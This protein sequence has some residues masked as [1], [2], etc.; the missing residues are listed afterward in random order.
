MIPRENFL[1]PGIEKRD[2]TSHC[3]HEAN[4]MC[5][6]VTIYTLPLQGNTPQGLE[7]H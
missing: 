7:K 2:L 4:Y 3:H 1:V 5:V 6:S